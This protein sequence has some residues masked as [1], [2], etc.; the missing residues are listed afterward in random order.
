MSMHELT[1][2]YNH[3]RP[4]NSQ[5]VLPFNKSD[6]HIYYISISLNFTQNNFKE[7]SIVS[8]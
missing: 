3:I 7:L 1:N 6:T 5:P 8:D 2:G 4:P